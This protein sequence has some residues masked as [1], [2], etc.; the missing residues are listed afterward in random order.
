MRRSFVVW[1]RCCLLPSRLPEFD[2]LH[3]VHTMLTERIK[4]WPER[5]K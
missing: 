2:A 3:E 1:F 5:W 4:K